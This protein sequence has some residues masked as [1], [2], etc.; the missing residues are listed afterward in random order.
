MNG[1]V[2]MNKRSYSF[3][4]IELLVVIAIIAILAGMLLPA[5]A[6]ARDKARSISCV[7]NLRQIGTGMQLYLSEANFFPLAS[8]LN[9]VIWTVKI[10]RYIGQAKNDS[11]SAEHLGQT[12]YCPQLYAE[13]YGLKG[14]ANAASAVNAYRSTYSFNNQLISINSTKI[15]SPGQITKPSETALLADCRPLTTSGDLSWSAFFGKV[16]AIQFIKGDKKTPN[17][18]SADLAIGAVHGRGTDIAFRETCNP[19]YVDGHVQPFNW[20]AVKNFYYA[21]FAYKNVSGNTADMWE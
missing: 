18:D 11:S 3:T 15:I 21:P 2:K 12:F 16:Q 17:T 9:G 20:R 6:K 14:N 5:L 4:L 10:G 13:G 1:D 7:N 19:L 8:P